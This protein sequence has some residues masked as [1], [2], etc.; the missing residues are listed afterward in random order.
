MDIQK[1][2]YFHAVAKLSH[3][4]KAAELLCVAQPAV[5][6]AVRSLEAELGVPL[7]EKRGRNVTLTEYGLHL[8]SRLD[9]LIPEFEGLGQ[10]IELMKNK[11]RKTVKLN[12]LAASTYVVNAIVEYRKKEAD[13]VFDFE[14]SVSKADCDI[15]IK[16]NCHE[17][18][19]SK[20]Y[21][22]RVV[23]TE[24]IYLAVPKNSVYAERESISLYDVRDEGIVMLTS[25][26]LFG[27]ICEKFCLA[28]GFSPKILFESDSPA[29]VQNIISSGSGIA[30]WPECSW[31]QVNT[32]NLVLIP[33]SE[34][35]CQRELIFEF[36]SRV[37]VSEY[38]EDFFE[39]LIK[40]I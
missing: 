2:K 38:A 1:L 21:T 20:N 24:R 33:V 6:Q 8:K 12:I 32:D 13:A 18:S 5:T 9:V 27:R 10:E 31:G 39:S 29:V 4:T 25:A 35:I 36:Y 37:P 23:K 15:V 19:G 40:G 30:F 17:D 26:R 3:V 28:A 7:L 16:T 14:Q 22:K 34:P 11:N